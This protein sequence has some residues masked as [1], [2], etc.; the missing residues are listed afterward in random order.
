M[1]VL[2]YPI[3]NMDMMEKYYDEI[4]LPLGKNTYYKSTIE[5]RNEWM[6][7]NSDS[8]V[9]YV[10]R[11]FGGAARCLCKAQRKGLNIIQIKIS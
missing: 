6:I 5:K 1:L 11:N 9:A 7:K 2:P 8:L 10:I 3:A 4:L